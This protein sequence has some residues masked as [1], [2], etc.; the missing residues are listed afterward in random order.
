MWWYVIFCYVM[1]VCTYV[2]IHNVLAFNMVVWPYMTIPK[3]MDESQ[4]TFGATIGWYM[5]QQVFCPSPDLLCPSGVHHSLDVIHE[6]A[7]DEEVVGSWSRIR[8]ENL[9]RNWALSMD[10]LFD[11]KE[12]CSKVLLHHYFLTCFR[13]TSA[14]NYGFYLCSFPK[15]CSHNHHHQ[16][17]HHQQQHHHHHPILGW[18]QVGELQSHRLFCN[19]HV[20]S[21]CCIWSHLRFQ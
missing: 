3:W 7:P 1:Y 16:H 21:A 19:F 18:P 5:K 2:C 8:G 12:I 4:P 14:G 17:H 13:G 15:I 10:G 20:T 9:P 6:V 11:L